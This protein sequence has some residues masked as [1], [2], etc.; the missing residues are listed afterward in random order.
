MSVLRTIKDK[1]LAMFRITPATERSITIQE[2]MSFQTRVL[3]NQV[4]YHGD[5]SELQQFFEAAACDKATRSRFWAASYK[6]DMRKVHSGVPRLV[7][8]KFRD[9]VASD[10]D[11]ITIADE[12]KQK[13]W[14]DELYEG[15]RFNKSLRKGLQGALSSGDGA[16][17]ISMDSNVSQYPILEFYPASQV[18]FI[19][20]KSFLVGV[21]FYKTYH[22]DKREYQL[23]E[24]YRF[25]SISYHLY[26]TYGKEVPLECV[27]EL[28]GLEDFQ[29]TKGEP[30]LLAVPLIIFESDRWE[31]R[32]EALM[33][34]KVEALDVL[35]EVLSQF[36]HNFRIGRVQKYVPEDMLPRDIN[37]GQITR[38]SDF[39]DQFIQVSSVRSETG[40]GEQK[41]QVVVPEILYEAYLQGKASYLD[42]CLS[43]I[44]SP[45]SL[46]ID[47]KKTD[48]AEAQREKE[49]A[50]MDTRSSI[51][52][53]LNEALPDLVG[54]I[55]QAYDLSKHQVP[56]SYDV[57]VS[58]GE[59]SA[60]SFDTVVEVVGKAKAY[61]I[62][63]LEKCVDE[64]YGDT[65]TD[66]QKA[67]EVLRIRTD[68][69][70]FQTEEPTLQNNFDD[71][72]DLESSTTLLNGAQI[73]SM[74]GVVRSVAAGELSLNAAISIITSTLGVS[75]ENAEQFIDEQKGKV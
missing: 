21:D 58:F 52:D 75:R 7:V 28:A 24:E 13:L 27:D 17:K 55:L 51:I 35:D 23:K 53:V 61:G 1:L 2:P 74:L 56:G 67:E 60:P 6:S 15:C 40:G 22:Q 62:M 48:N 68:S 65:L 41:I 18:D 36:A 46:G 32:G 57:S 4:L 12:S 30:V 59:Y 8:N 20:D 11:K 47:L 73:T 26:D 38:S 50:T 10:L 42:D 70:G 43:G 44:I 3:M 34:C 33:D 37:T 54:A 39:D 5:V 63:S 25:G 72:E 14:D 49:K 16:W 69:G 31:G 66:E 71:D 9:L 19:Y 64:L 29:Q 45:C